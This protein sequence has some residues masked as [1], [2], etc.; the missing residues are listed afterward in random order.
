MFRDRWRGDMG[1]LC[2]VPI[3]HQPPAPPLIQK[4]QH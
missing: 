2:H 4:L 1:M 3:A